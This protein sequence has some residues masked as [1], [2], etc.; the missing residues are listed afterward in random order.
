M[1]DGHGVLNAAE[2]NEVASQVMGVR[3][4]VLFEDGD[5]LLGAS[6]AGE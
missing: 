1:Q 3:G 2:V 6:R 5:S 4:G